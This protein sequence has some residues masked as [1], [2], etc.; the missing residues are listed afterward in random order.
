[1][2]YWNWDEDRSLSN[3]SAGYVSSD[4]GKD[5]PPIQFQGMQQAPPPPT[6]YKG[7]SH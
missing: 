1:M 6:T 4:K 7:R 3:G 2:P 5:K